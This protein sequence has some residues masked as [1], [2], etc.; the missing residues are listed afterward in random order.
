M[1]GK[2]FTFEG[3]DGSGK[4]TISKMVYEELRKKWDVVLTKEPTDSWLGKSV[5]KAIEEKKDAITISLLFMADRN[6]HLKDIH[7]WIEEGK[8][9]LCDRY[10]DSTFAYQSAHLDDVMDNPL[11]WLKGVHAPFFIKPDKTFL[12]IIEP[13]K[14]ISR[15]KERKKT[16]FENE[17]FLE[18]VQEYYLVLSKEKRFVKLDATKSKEELK[19]KC[20]KRIK[21]EMGY[22]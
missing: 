19:E 3:I 12:F 8:V 20:I 2:F 7:K 18:K 13:S 4:T 21:E 14:A 17:S 22:E 1:R 16:F 10:M 11:R 6:E 9:V 15:I 5:E